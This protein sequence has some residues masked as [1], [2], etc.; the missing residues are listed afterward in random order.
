MNLNAAWIF[1]DGSCLKNPAGPGGF[2]G[3]L[4]IPE[5]GLGPEEIFQEGH[6]ETTNIRMELRALVAALE[7]TKNNVPF[8]RENGIYEVEIFS[9]SLYAINA[10]KYGGIWKQNG[11]SDP[12]GI[13]KKNIELI[14][15]IN[16]LKNSVGI[17]CSP[18]WIQN[19]SSEVTKRVDKLAKEAAKKVISKT[20]FGYIKPR[21]SKTKVAGRT[22]PFEARGQTIFIR[23]FEY[24]PMSRKGSMDKVK[25]EHTC[26]GSLEKN[27]AYLPKRLAA[28]LHRWHYYEATFNDDSKNNFKKP[29]ILSLIEAEESDFINP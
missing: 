15:R 11:W 16:S 13:S 10:Y 28:K 19:K 3:I 12:D 27:Y 18:Q 21:A 22:M 20:D 7:W 6:R 17:T 26:N 9:D 24:S 8:L 2:A 5:I 25:F 1:I 23:V 29:K 4:Q 14:K